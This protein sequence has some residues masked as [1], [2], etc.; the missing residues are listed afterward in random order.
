MRYSGVHK[1]SE[2]AAWYGRDKRA[3][4]NALRVFLSGLIAV[5]LAGCNSVVTRTGNSGGS[6]KSV[7]TYLTGAVGNLQTYAIDHTSNPGTFVVTSY[8]FT[9]GT[10][11]STG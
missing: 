10:G 1:D 4:V 8:D 3:A 11:T 6:Q 2:S 5:W 9:G 7:P